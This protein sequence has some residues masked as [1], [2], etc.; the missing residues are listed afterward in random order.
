M[1]ESKALIEKK[2]TNK[3]FDVGTR[4]AS[5]WYQVSREWTSWVFRPWRSV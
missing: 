3:E 2:Y 1:E 5:V 4:A